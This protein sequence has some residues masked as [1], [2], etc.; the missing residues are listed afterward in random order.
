MCIFAFSELVVL[1][2]GLLS[3]CSQ[4]YSSQ[5]PGIYYWP[6]L[7]IKLISASSR[8]IRVRETNRDGLIARGGRL[9]CSSQP[10][11]LRL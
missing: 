1:W 4:V 11:L 10:P 2:P 9:L 5:D 3:R 7:R 6:V 8:S